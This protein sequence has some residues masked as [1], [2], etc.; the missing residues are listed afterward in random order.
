MC[1]VIGCIRMARH[2]HTWVQN[3]RWVIG[4]YGRAGLERTFY[5]DEENMTE[6]KQAEELWGVWCIATSQNQS[7]Q[8]PR[9]CFTKLTETEARQKA[10][11]QQKGN[12]MWEYSAKPM[13]TATQRAD[14]RDVSA[15]LG[16]IP[17]LTLGHDVKGRVS[18]YENL[19]CNPP[20]TNNHAADLADRLS[21][22][23]AQLAACS[24]QLRHEQAEVVRLREYLGP[25]R[26]A[27]YDAIRVKE[28]KT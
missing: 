14:E 7:G 5:K 4:V 1:S 24:L 25:S 8:E 11:R 20:A 27:M 6:Q 19:V 2:E 17:G 10:K 13:A 3:N 22:A 9:F 23:E 21:I 15:K 12:I 28:K 26:S 18:S 16:L